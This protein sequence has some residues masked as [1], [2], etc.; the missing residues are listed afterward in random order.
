MRILV[1]PLLNCCLSKARSCRLRFSLYHPTCF[2]FPSPSATQLRC[3]VFLAEMVSPAWRPLTLLLWLPTTSFSS[4]MRTCPPACWP[5]QH[6]AKLPPQFCG[7]CICAAHGNGNWGELNEMMPSWIFS[8]MNV[9]ASIGSQAS[10]VNVQKRNCPP[11]LCRLSKGAKIYI[12][13]VCYPLS[14]TT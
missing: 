1:L 5:S 12:S 8:L 10:T 2:C 14:K 4:W 6:L 9:S 3:C 7:L 11:I 13:S